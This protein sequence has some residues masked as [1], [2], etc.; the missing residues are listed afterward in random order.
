M[1]GGRGTHRE[2]LPAA[3]T[4]VPHGRYGRLL[5]SSS[6]LDKPDARAESRFSY[7]PCHA[8]RGEPAVQSRPCTNGSPNRSEFPY[9]LVISNHSITSPV[10]PRTRPQV[11]TCPIFSAQ[12]QLTLTTRFASC[13]Y[14]A[15][16][17]TA[18]IAREGR[19]DRLLTRSI[20]STDMTQVGPDTRCAQVLDW[21]PDR[22]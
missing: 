1:P 16:R 17:K 21:P 18:G 5:P 9:L 13:Y 15:I 11:P 12:R 20:S 4:S 2:P 14:P 10:A 6:Q 8:A 3:R 19:A 22:W 7:K